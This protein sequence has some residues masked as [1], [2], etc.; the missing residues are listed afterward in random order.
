MTDVHEFGCTA[1]VGRP[2]ICAQLR[3]ERPKD[4]WPDAVP[5]QVFPGPDADAIPPIV[6]RRN[7]FPEGSEAERQMFE[8]MEPEDDSIPEDVCRGCGAPNVSHMRTERDNYCG[9]CRFPDRE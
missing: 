3:K 5:K 1:Y 8:A 2:C 9:E 7:P 4:S 6:L